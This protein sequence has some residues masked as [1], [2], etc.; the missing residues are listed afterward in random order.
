MNIQL[1]SL[2]FQKTIRIFQSIFNMKNECSICFLICPISVFLHH[3]FSFKV[4]LLF[5]MKLKFQIYETTIFVW[6]EEEEKTLN[7]NEIHYWNNKRMIRMKKFSWQ[8]KFHSQKKTADFCQI[9]KK[10][11]RI[12]N[13]IIKNQK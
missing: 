10:N 11:Q 8:R 5:Q 4:S 7:Y 6:K 13:S 3:E 2:Q 12:R 9:S 1:N